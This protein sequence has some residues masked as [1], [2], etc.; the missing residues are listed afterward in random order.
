MFKI[1]TL[2]L[3]LGL[4]MC[5]INLVSQSTS[6]HNRP[7]PRKLEVLAKTPESHPKLDNIKPETTKD[8]KLFLEEANMPQGNTYVNE[9][10]NT[11]SNLNE[12]MGHSRRQTEMK[13]VGQWF[14]DVDERLDDFRD[15]VSRKLN[16]LHMALQRPKV[17][18]FHQFGG[19]PFAAAASMQGSISGSAGPSSL[20][21]PTV[22]NSLSAGS[23]MRSL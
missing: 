12:M 3:T 10:Q 17:P 4:T 14:S 2:F 19:N 16:E 7:R 21:L 23:Q 5:D 6:L 20:A 1:L 11:N 13:Q 18:M 8:R 15:A 9:L 22:G